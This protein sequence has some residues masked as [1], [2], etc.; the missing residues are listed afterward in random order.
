MEQRRFHADPV[1]GEFMLLEWD[2]SRNGWMPAV[3]ILMGWQRGM[4]RI[5]GQ[6][7]NSSQLV[8]LP[9]FMTWS[10]LSPAEVP[11]IRTPLARPWIQNQFIEYAND[12]EDMFRIAGIDEPDLS[13]A[14]RASLS[15]PPR[16]RETP[17]PPPAFPAHLVGPVLASAEAD[18][19]ICPITMD[20]IRKRTAAITSCGH[21]FQKKAIQEWLAS[22]DTCPEC[23]QRCSL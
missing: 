2:D 1:H 8:T 16:P 18:R 22:H 15:A 7:S 17:P 10:R 23:R 9:D 20:P 14:I 6:T 19:K 3:E 13:L 5:F 12:L 21:I 11:L 4:H